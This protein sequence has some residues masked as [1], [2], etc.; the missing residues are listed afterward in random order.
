MFA[1]ALQVVNHEH[2]FRYLVDFFELEARRRLLLISN[3]IFLELYHLNVVFQ[4]PD[5]VVQL[6]DVKIKLC[7]LLNH[8]ILY[9]R[10]LK[11]LLLQIVVEP[12]M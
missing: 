8:L 2:N 3:F 1:E 7:L 9:F 4:F 6:H 12:V 10:H 11:L 5:I